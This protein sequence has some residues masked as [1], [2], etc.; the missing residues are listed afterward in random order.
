MHKLDF[1]VNGGRIFPIGVYETKED[2]K[3]AIYWHIYSYSAIQHPVFR[4][5]G[6]DEVKRVDYGACDCYFLVKE[7][8]S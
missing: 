1:V 2:V 3:Q 8:E 4:T 6:S 5:S 7:V